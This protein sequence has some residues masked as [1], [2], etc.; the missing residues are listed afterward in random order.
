M[1]TYFGQLYHLVIYTFAVH[2]PVQLLVESE[3]CHTREVD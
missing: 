3:L 1:I 2:F